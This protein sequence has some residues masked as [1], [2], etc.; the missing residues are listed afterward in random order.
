M[1]I[2][3]V[4]QSSNQTS[5]WKFLGAAEAGASVSDVTVALASTASI[6]LCVAR[7]A[8]YSAN[9]AARWNF[10]GQK[11]TTYSQSVGDSSAAPTASTSTLGIGVATGLIQ[12]VRSIV[13]LLVRKDTAAGAAG[14]IGWGFSATEAAATGG[15]ANDT[16]GIWVG[17]SLIT[18]ITLNRGPGAGTLNSGTRV[19]VWGCS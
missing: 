9:N 1:G 6:Y 14:C 15:V 19:M 4:I 5:C 3:N 16:R 17:S 18:Q 13:V 8:G 2:M 7:I 11:T 12:A 10:N